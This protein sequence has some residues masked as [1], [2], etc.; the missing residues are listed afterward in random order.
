MSIAEHRLIWEQRRGPIP[1]GYVIHFLN[2][3]KNDTR[4]VNMAAV[5]RYR[6]IRLIVSPYA[7]RIRKLERE[8]IALKK[9]I[10]ED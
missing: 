6:P 10:G 5:P 4:D 7:R 8:L 9:T 1:K 3:D 2:G